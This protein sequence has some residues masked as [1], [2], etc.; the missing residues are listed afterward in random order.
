LWPGGRASADESVE[1][2]LFVARE[3]GGDDVDLVALFE[4]HARV[5]LDAVACELG[6]EP[7]AESPGSS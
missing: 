3:I 7:V 4:L 1:V 2:G 6:A 5:L